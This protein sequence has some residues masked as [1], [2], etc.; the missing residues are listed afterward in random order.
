MVGTESIAARRLR[1]FGVVV[2]DINYLETW[3]SLNAHVQTLD[4]AKLK[5]LLK[6]E[7][8]GEKRTQFLIRLYG[9]YNKLRTIRERREMLAK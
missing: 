9:R 4:E 1:H 2:E 8:R 5:S 7:L 6:Q 3:A